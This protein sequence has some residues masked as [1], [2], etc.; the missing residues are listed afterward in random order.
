M[1][2]GELD[3]DDYIFFK[4]YSDGRKTQLSK[5]YISDRFRPILK[6]LGLYDDTGY[7]LYSFKAK[8]N[9]DKLDKM[10]WSLIQLQKCNRHAT[11]N[12]TLTYLKNI[13]KV[14][15]IDNLDS[16]EL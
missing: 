10:G 2:L 13:G 4:Q 16:I 6:N 7:D 15:D 1:N 11:V 3:K 14:T 12:Q 5:S 8:G 9:L